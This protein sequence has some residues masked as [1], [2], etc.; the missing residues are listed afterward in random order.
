MATEAGP[1][2]EQMGYVDARS[3]GPVLAYPI[4]APLAGQ[5]HIGASAPAATASDGE[6]DSDE[7]ADGQHVQA[8]EAGPRRTGKEAGSYTHLTLPTLY[9]V[10]I[11]GVAGWS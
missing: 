6:G 1:A 5:S 7:A 9:A 2:H 11:L 8:I 3:D 4:E 10:E